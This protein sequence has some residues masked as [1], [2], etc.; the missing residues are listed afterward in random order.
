MRLPLSFA[1]AVLLS[2]SLSLSLS[3]CSGGT[4][5]DDVTGIPASWLEKTADG[6]TASDAF[7]GDMPVLTRERCQLG[8][9]VPDVLGEKPEITDSGWGSYG[10]DPEAAD[11]YR[12]VCDFW[13]EG[14]FAGSLQLIHAADPAT[15]EQTLEDFVSQIDTTDQDNTVTTVRV[16]QLDVHVLARWYPT[17]PQGEYQALYLDTENNALAVFEVNSLK[18]DDYAEY[19]DTRVA[20]DLVTALAV[21]T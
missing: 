11:S 20:E 21:G 19:S 5:T 13:S 8:D 7:G 10:D 3:G 1:L 14:R 16:G 15:A 9:V 12:Y 18:D 6:W 2:A 17:N 4:E